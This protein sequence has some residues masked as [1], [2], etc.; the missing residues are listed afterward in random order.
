MDMIIELSSLKILKNQSDQ[1]YCECNIQDKHSTRQGTVLAV[2]IR[3]PLSIAFVVRV[4]AQIIV[5]GRETEF[6]WF[7]VQQRPN[8]HGG[9]LPQFGCDH[10]LG[11][12]NGLHASRTGG[13]DTIWSIL[14][15]QTLFKWKRKAAVSFMT[16]SGARS[17]SLSTPQY[18]LVNLHFLVWVYPQSVCR[19]PRKCPVLVCQFSHLDRSSPSPC[20]WTG[21]TAPRD[22]SFWFRPFLCWSSWPAPLAHRIC[23]NAGANV[24]HLPSAPNY[25]S[26]DGRAPRRGG[27]IRRA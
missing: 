8:D 6:L 22:W 1:R 12:H 14:K 5:E 4:L 23:A 15:H 7:E 13:A 21:W 10:V 3:R 25:G 2:W 9:L 11:D 17:S 26:A 18:L 24:R 27:G 16:R 20:G 19:R